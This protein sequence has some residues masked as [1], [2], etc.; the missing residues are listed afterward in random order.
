MNKKVCIMY[1][2]GWNLSDLT[3]NSHKSLYNY[4]NKNNIKYDVFISVS[5]EIILKSDKKE[6]FENSLGKLSNTNK[7]LNFKKECIRPHP[8]IPTI[9][10]ISKFIN[11][12]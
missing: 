1:T 5:N 12:N 11:N 3:I 8:L 2:G 9:F 10:Y 4:F 7:L 6:L